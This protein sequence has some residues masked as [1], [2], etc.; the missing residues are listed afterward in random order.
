MQG[1]SGLGG[2]EAGV[3]QGGG[4]AGGSAGRVLARGEL[5]TGGSQRTRCGRDKHPA[6]RALLGCRISVGSWGS[7]LARLGQKLERGHLLVPGQDPY[8]TPCPTGAGGG[9][10]PLLRLNTGLSPPAVSRRV[11]GTP[12]GVCNVCQKHLMYGAHFG[13]PEAPTKD[14]MSPYRGQRPVAKA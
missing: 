13:Q 5:G 14:L 1:G 4:V 2:G 9:E 10:P 6:G 11:M 7:H 3:C 12:A 8:V